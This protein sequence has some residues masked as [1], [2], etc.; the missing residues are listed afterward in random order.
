M[1]EATVHL[2]IFGWED[3]NNR[4]KDVFFDIYEMHLDDSDLLDFQDPPLHTDYVN[5][6][7]SIDTVAYTLPSPG[8]YSV[9]ARVR[10]TVNNTAY[11]RGLLLYDPH[12]SIE[13]AESSLEVSGARQVGINYWLSILSP[14]AGADVTITWEGRYSNAFYQENDVLGQVRLFSN[15]HAN[16]IED[17]WGRRAS[18][19]VH[20]IA[21][22]VQYNYTLANG[23]MQTSSSMDAR[24]RRQAEDTE[25]EVVTPLAES[26]TVN[27]PRTD[28]DA[29]TFKLKALDL[30]GNE[31][32]DI[33]NIR[34]DSTPPVVEGEPEFFRNTG[35][36]SQ[37]FHSRHVTVCKVCKF[38]T[39]LDIDV[40]KN[41]S[42]LLDI[43]D[44]IFMYSES[45]L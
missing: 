22:I 8:L 21:G 28:G 24:V 6:M 9:V 35:F 30:T 4:V 29:F 27:L 43:R 16:G 2:G 19:A 11:A 37:L 41:K 36:G 32:L 14:P 25:W 31:V 7:G 3:K 40:A 5:T 12:S 33:I 38:N 18:H 45:C 34:V 10:D 26:L 13:T 23:T 39:I 17:R 44:P 15:H 20:N 1:Q 42:A